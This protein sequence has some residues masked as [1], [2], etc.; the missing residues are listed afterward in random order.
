MRSLFMSL[1][2]LAVSGLALEARADIS[3]N[4]I[5]FGVEPFITFDEFPLGDKTGTEWQPD[6]GIVFAAA[7]LRTDDL[8]GFPGIDGPN[9][10]GQ[11]L[12]GFTISFDDPTSSF[13]MAWITNPGTTTF[14]AFLGNDLVEQVTLPTNFND[15]D[16]AF[17]VFE[18]ITFDRIFATIDA[19]FVSFRIDN[20]QTL[21]TPATSVVMLL[22]AAAGRRRR[23]R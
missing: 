17:T 5:G 19:A 20:L 7:L 11:A 18:N 14:Q 22:A 10:V 15:P 12:K 9:L 23:R 13:A 3:T 2:A 1:G 6:F 8:D 4:S 21:P 16:I